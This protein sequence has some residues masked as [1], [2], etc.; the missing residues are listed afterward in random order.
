[1]VYI[2]VKIHARIVVKIHARCTYHFQRHNAGQHLQ[3]RNEAFNMFPIPHYVFFKAIVVNKLSNSSS[4]WWD[5]ASVADCSQL[6]ALLRRSVSFNTVMWRLPH[7]LIYVL[8]LL[9]NYLTM[10]SFRFAN[11]SHQKRVTRT[12]S[13]HS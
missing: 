10:M 13:S 3:N 5:H 6:K 4:A 12:P 7:S 8:R 2:V 11:F 1:M 9:K